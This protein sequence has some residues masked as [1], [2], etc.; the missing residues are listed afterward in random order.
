MFRHP[1]HAALALTVVVATVASACAPSTATP[2]PTGVQAAEGQPRRGGKIN[3]S[4]HNSPAT[5]NDFLNTQTVAGD[6]RSFVVEGLTAVLRD[7]SRVGQL[8]LDVP[9]PRN[10]GL[11]ADGTTVT[12]KL[13]PGVLWSDGT[14]FGCDDVKFTFQTRMTPGVGIVGTTGYDQ[15]TSLDC[16]DQLT[17]VAKLKTF[18]AAYYTLFGGILP[19]TAGDPKNIKNWAY[20]TK[21][22]GTGPFKVDEWVA[23][24]HITMSRNDKYREP[25]KPYLDQINFRI[26]PSV[27]VAT[28]LLRS[29][30]VDVM[31]MPKLDQMPEFDKMPGVKY[32]A[33]PRSGGEKLFLNLGE[34]KD[35]ADPTKPHLILSD[36]RVR[37]A[38]AV[39]TNWQRIAD[40]L[41]FG[42]A[43][44]STGDLSEG[45]WKCDPAIPQYKY[46]PAQAKALLTDAG[47]VPGADGIRVAK[48]AKIAP[49]GTRLRLKFTTTTGDKLREDTQLLI[50]QDMRAVGMEIYVEN[51][52]TSV[53]TGNWD[54][55]AQRVHGNFDILMHSTYAGS[56]PHSHM[57]DFW[58]SASIPSVNNKGGRNYTRFNDPSADAILKT[59][60]AEIDPAKRKAAYCKLAQM[61]HDQANI[62]YTYQALRIHAYR[63]RLV[64]FQSNAWD[65]LGWNAADWWVSK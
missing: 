65:N 24:D 46:D 22:I 62:L 52:P 44:V 45:A 18:Y 34:N 25:G 47:W 21:P 41:M 9:S 51:G 60:A 61:T 5:L 37:M 57:V 1:F 38:I 55:G 31:W 58:S 28:Q 36:Q 43:K 27:E 20:N 6:I 12:W 48:G 50:I 2:S 15:I 26:V 19:R 39:G 8:A 35:P 16:P 3:V 40:D 10:G 54:S 29:G 11:S 32:D 53:I 4:L 30:E 7:G 23:D 63:D 33:P 56:D 64:G 42:K 49:D 14:A 59:A 13:R 17:V